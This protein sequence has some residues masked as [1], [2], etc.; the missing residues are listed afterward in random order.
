ME[1]LAQPLPWAAG[2][3]D[4]T[5]AR[6]STDLEVILGACRALP[7][8][9]LLELKRRMD[10]L[11]GHRAEQQQSAPP[12]ESET[13]RQQQKKILKGLVSGRTDR[14]R[15]KEASQAAKETP[16]EKAARLA[17]E[18]GE[19]KRAEAERAR[20]EDGEQARGGLSKKQ[21]M[22]QQRLNTRKA[23]AGIR[24]AKTGA[25]KHKFDAE[26]H[27]QRQAAKGKGKDKGVQKVICP[28][29]C[30]KMIP[31]EL[32][33][34]GSAWVSATTTPVSYPLLPLAVNQHAERNSNKVKEKKIANKLKQKKK[35]G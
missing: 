31:A 28:C 4:R 22:E 30:G 32:Y 2:G 15:R 3:A 18:E 24:Q 12:D 11:E 23:R 6:A 20:L 10:A 14:L 9:D 25:S 26:A 27:A 8:Q 19:R 17:R 29:G 16:E 1:A 5:P 34:T 21:Q 33:K 7:D 35:A 13:F